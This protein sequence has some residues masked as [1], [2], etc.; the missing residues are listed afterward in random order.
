[1]PGKVDITK[2]K[3]KGSSGVSS[4]KDKVASGKA[5]YL[6]KGKNEKPRNVVAFEIG[7]KHIKIVEGKYSKDKLSIYKMGQVETPMASIEDGA[8]IDERALVNTLQVAINQ[9]G[10]KSKDAV[11]TSNSSSIID[12]E[13]I[14]PAVDESE[15][16]S[17]I[18]Y[19]IQQYLPINLDEYI[20]EYVVIDK[21][22]DSE[23]PKLKVNVISYPKDIVNGYYKLIKSLGLNPYVLDVTYNSLKKIVNHTGMIKNGGQTGTVAFVDMGATSINVTIFKR[24]Q[25]DFTRIIKSGGE[26]IDQALSSRLDMSIKST[27]SMKMDKGN[28]LDIQD[29]DEVNVI[30]KET[31]DEMIGEL[32][33]ILQFASNK[34]GENV[35]EVVIYGGASKLRGLDVYMQRK[36]LKSIKRV[37]TL[38]RIDI[39][40]SAMPK[41]PIGEYLNAIGAVI[42]QSQDVNFLSMYQGKNGEAVAKGGKIK[43][44]NTPMYIVVGLIAAAIVVTFLYHE[45]AIKIQ[46]SKITS[47]EEKM[48]EPE[49]QKQL[50]IA[51]DL[52]NKISSVTQYNTQV[53]QITKVVNSRKVVTPEVLDD[54]KDAVPGGVLYTSYKISNT[55]ITITG[56]SPS[57]EVVAEMEHNFRVLDRVQDVHVATIEGDGAVTFDITIKIKQIE[58][59]E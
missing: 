37:F 5:T 7:S 28:L 14:I 51:Q 55:E 21:L 42:R 30:I 3:K 22:V 57:T 59:A 25:L 27:E 45:I 2:L 34:N 52:A 12:R 11:V 4:L 15:M 10:I 19:E 56:A 46:E 40:T 50:A 6:G 23:G 31:V 36:L 58:E 49:F 26:T 47:I 43:E 18:K 8:I 20:V 35:D 24:G 17:V 44:N 53:E 54:V 39:S 13:I 29:D 1:M 32:E 48:A 9:L 38:E 16:E 33:Q 41:E